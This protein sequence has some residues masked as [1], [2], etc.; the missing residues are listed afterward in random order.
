MTP[1]VRLAG[2]TQRFG[3]RTVLDGIDLRIEAGQTIALLGP[4]GTG[5]TTLLR[6][7][8]GSLVPTRGTVEVLGAEFAKL[9]PRAL[10]RHRRR[11]GLLYQNDALVPGLRV[12]HNV[13]IGRLGAWSLGKSLWSLL[14]PRELD[15]VARALAE[16]D[17]ADRI[18][19]PVEALSGGQ[20]QRVAI[21][22][23]L[24]QDAELILADEPATHLDPRLAAEV[25]ELVVRT[26][27]THGRTAIVS[28]HDMDLIGAK[29][30]RVLA[31]KHGK[32]FLDGPP[33]AVTPK[34]VAELFDR[35]DTAAAS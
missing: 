29:F 14:F 16:V 10:R 11:I 13:L 34:V 4:S 19:A 3:E 25:V 8:A 9:S 12:V 35:K 5:K 2:V 26:A 27:R 32:W 18:Y 15:R 1:A 28:L 31:M 21:A 20:R 24:V 6:I 33:S 23:L 7:L 30:D 17:L 22:R